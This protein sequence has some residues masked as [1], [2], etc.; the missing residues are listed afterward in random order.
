[1][2]INIKRYVDITSGV[3]AGSNIAVRDLIGRFFT[4]NPLLPSNS[5]VQFTSAAQ[6]SA[7]FGSAS[8]EALRAAFYFGWISKNVT[9][10]DAIQFAR[11]VNADSA[12]QIFSVP[13]NGTLLANWTGITDGSFSLTL[14]GVTET[15][16]GLNFG[17]AASLAAVATIIQT[18]IRT[19]TGT[20]WTAA[21]V[22][23]NAT[24]GSFDFEGGDDTVAA[25]VSVAPGIVGTNI[26]GTGLLGWY[27]AATFTNGTYTPGAIWSD[28]V[29]EQTVTELLEG[30]STISNN[31][32]SFLFLNSLAITLADAI[33]AATWNEE[34][35]N[36]YLFCV[37]V[38]SSTYAAW[39][40]DSTGLGEFPGVALTL[41]PITTEYP[42]QIPMMIEAATDYLAVNSVQ[43][44]MFQT[45][46]TGITPSVSTDALADVYDAASVN[47]YGSTQTAGQIISFYQR[48]ILCGTSS[49]PLDM[50]TYVN[51]IWL[52][53]AATVA[54]MNLFLAL[55]QIAANQQGRSQI[56]TTLQ[57]VINLAL[58]NGTISV[59]KALTD[60]Q[61]L[62]IAQATGDAD[63]WHQ[64]QSIGYWIDCQ[65][66][67]DTGTPVIYTAEYTLI[68][69][70]D[71]VIR[72]VEGRDILI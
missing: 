56:L 24:T 72:K 63:A 2:A 3:G 45:N 55:N 69:S 54:I 18:A 34:Q 9:Q 67:P 64:V 14:G 40:N 15:F 59:N 48:G 47:Y 53:D 27:P 65:I 66:V 43:N 7:Y 44:Y 6:V 11:W 20:Q 70:K 68:Y 16:T 52:K 32:G 36:M 37:P 41:S 22:T 71:D 38:T 5:F 50:N 17:A 62:F 42:E 51:E 4:A 8:E 31:F 60:T 49:N 57:S 35:N 21:T 58:N 46:F 61:K 39:S 29:Q 30:S 12:P 25:A 33:E 1:M 23:Y 10:A 28:G 19:G 13:E 26:A